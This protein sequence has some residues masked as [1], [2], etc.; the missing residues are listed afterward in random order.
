MPIALYSNGFFSYWI[1]DKENRRNGKRQ[2]IWKT[3]KKMKRKTTKNGTNTTW[4]SCNFKAK[5]INIHFICVWEHQC[6]NKMKFFVKFNNVK[7]KLLNSFYLFVLC[8]TGTRWC[9]YVSLSSFWKSAA[10][11]ESIFM[12]FERL[13]ITIVMILFA[14]NST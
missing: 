7:E 11:T 1:N 8:W 9:K 4:N 6:L 5:Y 14:H 12:L 13:Q 3:E 2:K 10:L